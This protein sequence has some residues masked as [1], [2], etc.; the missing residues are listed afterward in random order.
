[1]GPNPPPAFSDDDTGDIVTIDKDVAQTSPFGPPPQ[2][3]Q[4]PVGHSPD[5]NRTE[6][7]VRRSALRRYAP[8][9]V[10]AAAVL[11]GAIFAVLSVNKMRD[12]LSGAKA[13]VSS[14]TAERARR[15]PTPGRPTRARR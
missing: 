1:M 4:S 5:P 3:Y 2:G 6:A 14:L 15:S 9:G 11:G 13:E 12:E 10:I 8:I 7:V